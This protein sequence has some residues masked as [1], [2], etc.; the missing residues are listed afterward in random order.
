MK[1]FL[2][3]SFEFLPIR[4]IIRIKDLEKERERERERDLVI[5]RKFNEPGLEFESRLILEGN[6]L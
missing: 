2:V 3:A 5:A 6:D 1:R 4:C